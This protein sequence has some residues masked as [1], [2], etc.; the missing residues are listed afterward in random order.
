MLYTHSFELGTALSNWIVSERQ[1]LAWAIQRALLQKAHQAKEDT[2]YT[3]MGQF[4]RK[5][6]TL[7][8][9]CPSVVFVDDCAE[10]ISLSEEKH[11]TALTFEE[12]LTLRVTP[13]IKS[14]VNAAINP[15]SKI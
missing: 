12:S 11:P 15:K 14:A 1:S 2:S 7:Y 5:A 4:A 6:V 9:P 3:L 13:P 8:V 10:L